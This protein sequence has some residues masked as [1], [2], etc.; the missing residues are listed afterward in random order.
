MFGVHRKASNSL[1]YGDSVRVPLAIFSIAQ[2]IKYLRRVS[3]MCLNDNDSLVRHA[4][5]EQRNNN[6]EWY[7]TWHMIDNWNNPTSADLNPV[8]I[9]TSITEQF[10]SEWQSS[11][12]TQN[13][14]E[15][16]NS[17]KDSFGEESYLQSLNY[18][19]RKAIARIRSCAHDLNIERWRYKTFINC[20]LTLDRLW[21]YCCKSDKLSTLFLLNLEHLPFYDPNPIIESESHVISTCPTYNHLRMNLSEGLKTLIVRNNYSAVM[22][23]PDRT[24]IDEFDIFLCKSYAVRHPKLK[25]S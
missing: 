5:E 25:T 14:L 1:C 3:D 13:K 4:F 23:D 24:L 11:C 8:D 15:F 17:V 22:A 7:R 6:L 18:Q 16:Y 20:F 9:Q 19:G 10:I 21:N 12:K 2:C